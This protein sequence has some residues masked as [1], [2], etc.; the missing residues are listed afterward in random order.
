MPTTYAIPQGNQ[1]MDVTL[2]TGNASA[3]SITNSGAMKPDLVWIK[4]RNN[5]WSNAL[6]DAV[7][8]TGKYLK[9]NSTDA[10]ST[11][12]N[13]LTSFNSNGFSLGSVGGS[14]NSN[15]D[16]YVA[17]Q[18]RASGTTVSNTAGSITSTV[19]VN[20]TAGFSIATYTGTG[21][22]ATVGHGLGVAPKM[23]IVKRRDSTGSWPVYNASLPSA[24]YEMFLERTEAAGTPSASWN[25]TAPTSTVF[26]IGTGVAVNVNGGTYVA[27]CWSE[28]N[29]FSKIF[30]YTGNGSTDGPF[31]YCGFKPAYV[32]IKNSSTTGTDWV[33]ID[34]KR[35]GYNVTD[36][37]LN[38]NRDY[39]E[40]SGY[41]IDLLSNGFKIRTTTSY[42]NTNGST[43]V[44][45]AFAE[46]PFKYANAR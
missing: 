26:S 35:L 23:V 27:Y 4:S 46:N 8:G 38:P 34:N 7:R 33:A 13:S 39:A 37:A 40:N 12:A 42:M 10:E 15:G 9:S 29:G 1:Y 44:F 3:R 11:D 31:V 32:L 43:Y 5:T 19:S 18:W 28:V 24:A 16:T 25:N 30:S 45:M 14:F 21:S 22:N 41:S 6:T 20:T 2:Y 17:W 36:V